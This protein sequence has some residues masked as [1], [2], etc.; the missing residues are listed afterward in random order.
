MKA[1]SLG[2]NVSATAVAAQT[3]VGATATP[4]LEGRDCILDI[5]KAGVTGTPT[6]LFQTSPDNTTWTTQ[7]TDTLLTNTLTNVICGRYNRV[8]V[9]VAGSAGTFTAA[10]VNG[11]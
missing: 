2:S 1:L 10:L 3:G 6:I 5:R 8:N 9:T 11:A 4:F 7:A